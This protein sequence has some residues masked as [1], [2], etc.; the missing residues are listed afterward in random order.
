M[1]NL[2][3][4][5]LEAVQISEDI[6][7][8]FQREGFTVR[9]KSDHP[10]DTATEAD[11][12]CE[13]QLR[14][15]F[16]QHFPHHNIF[17]EEFGASYNGNGKVVVLDPIDGTFSFINGVPEYGTIAGIQEH[18]KLVAGVVSNTM[19]S[20]AYVCTPDEGFCRIGPEEK[21]IKEVI[22][23]NGKLPRDHGRELEAAL[24]EEFPHNPVIFRQQ[25]VTNS[26]RVFEGSWAA[27]F[28]D[29]LAWHDLSPHPLFG[30]IRGCV[31]SDYSGERHNFD[32]AVELEKYQSKNHDALYSHSLLV[33]QPQYADGMLRV[34]ERFK[35]VL[36][37]P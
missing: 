16:A 4:V 34:L 8:R 3:E 9:Q 24:R 22:M 28:H 21:L 13:R 20:I 32:P 11:E 17:G 23:V 14:T 33:A 1:K 15:F 7:R 35:D 10:Y 27:F 18:G 26:C 36:K 31:V 6:Q 25:G 29:T 30:D 19:K 12:E 37:R 5:L 2:Q